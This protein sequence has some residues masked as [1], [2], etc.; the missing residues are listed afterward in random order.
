MKHTALQKNRAATLEDGTIVP[1]WTNAD[2][3]AA[4]LARNSAQ[5][6]LE[7]ARAAW[8]A[9]GKPDTAEHREESARLQSAVTLSNGIYSALFMR[10]FSAR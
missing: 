2:T 3:R 9:G 1:S 10:D 8:E 5:R 6:D 4:C 7:E